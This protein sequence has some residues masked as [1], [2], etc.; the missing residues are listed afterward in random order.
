MFSYEFC[1]PLRDE[2]PKVQRI[3]SRPE[4]QPWPP[5][6]GDKM[7]QRH[8][9]ISIS[10]R[11]LKPD[12]AELSSKKVD[13]KPLLVSRIFAINVWVKTFVCDSAA[14]NLCVKIITSRNPAGINLSQIDS[15]MRKYAPGPIPL[16]Y[17]VVLNV[18]K[19]STFHSRYCHTYQTQI[20]SHHSRSFSLPSGLVTTFFSTS[21]ADSPILRSAVII[22]IPIDAVG[23]TCEDLFAI[24]KRLRIG[25]DQ[26][27]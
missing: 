14:S 6:T 11:D 19:L 26:I 9:L 23:A 17:L 24:V 21:G 22:S 12:P 13:V 18:G 4:S 3:V 8:L 16:I 25:H 7:A 2:E 1:R 10:G 27:T 15:S 20:S 5:G